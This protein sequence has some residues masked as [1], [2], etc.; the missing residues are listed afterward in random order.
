MKK[1]PG[2]G[3]PHDKPELWR[4]WASPKM[5]KKKNFFW[6]MWEKSMHFCP[7]VFPKQKKQFLCHLYK[8]P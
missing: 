8:K 7:G 4:I 5:I 6:V 1:I 2:Q 3:N